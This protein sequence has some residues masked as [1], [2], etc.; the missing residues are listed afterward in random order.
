MRKLVVKSG[1]KILAYKISQSCD[2]KN[3]GR[4]ASYYLE[5]KYLCTS[6]FKKVKA[7]LEREG[8]EIIFPTY[9]EPQFGRIKSNMLIMINTGKR[10]KN[11]NWD[12]KLAAKQGRKNK[13]KSRRRRGPIKLDTL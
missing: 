3:C 8:L 7:K 6:C 5:Q 1:D 11:G 13:G 9:Q 4:V 2:G 10:V 12:K